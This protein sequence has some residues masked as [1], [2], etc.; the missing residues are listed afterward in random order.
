[1]FLLC[2]RLS[3]LINSD[4]LRCNL[5]IEKSSYKTL[6]PSNKIFSSTIWWFFFGDI[7]WEYKFYCLTMR[8]YCFFNLRSEF[9]VKMLV[10][11]IINKFKLLWVWLKNYKKV[12]HIFFVNIWFKFYRAFWN[13]F[14]ISKWHKI[15]STSVGPK[16][17]PIATPS[18][19]V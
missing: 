2:S 19:W 4:S 15:V 11:H 17:D 8:S 7:K 6:W 9:G 10:I 16:G 13:P 5:K 18:V 14:Q 12:I 3:L 1:M